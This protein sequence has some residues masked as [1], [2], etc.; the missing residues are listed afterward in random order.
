MYSV[1]VTMLRLL[2]NGIPPLGAAGA[3]A[4][5]EMVLGELLVGFEPPRMLEGLTVPDAWPG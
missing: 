3:P 5:L 1:L 2:F 4:M